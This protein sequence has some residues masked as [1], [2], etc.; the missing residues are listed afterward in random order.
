M[1]DTWM[2]NKDQAPSLCSVSCVVQCWVSP[3]VVRIMAAKYPNQQPVTT[4]K[5]LA[6]QPTHKQAAQVCSEV[7]YN[8][9]GQNNHAFA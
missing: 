7:P 5:S 3:E 8:G 1:F 4:Y 2:K 9:T 6:A